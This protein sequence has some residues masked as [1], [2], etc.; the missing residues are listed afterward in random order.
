[1][2]LKRE[3]IGKGDIVRR[4]ITFSLS[5]EKLTTYSVCG[6]PVIDKGLI[7]GGTTVSTDISHILEEK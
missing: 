1:M 4:N 6:A 7:I 5:D 3:V 2:E